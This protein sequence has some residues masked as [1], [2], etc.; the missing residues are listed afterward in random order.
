MAKTYK[1]TNR[2]NATKDR[3]QEL[4]TDP[5]VREQEAV[6]IARAIEAKCVVEH[7]RDGLTRLVVHQK[8]YGRGMD[9]KRDTS[10]VEDV[11]LTIDWNT[12][13]YR[14]DWTW[15]MASQKDRVHVKGTTA[16]VADGNAC[17]V[18]EE[19]HVEV[20]VPMIGKM[21]EGKVAA[22]IEKVRPRWVEWF[23]KKL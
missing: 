20:K 11:T 21:I 19:G 13:A 3:V 9:G 6:E 14:C 12:T 7:P 4:M 18:V 16:L 15:S 5:R 8:E 2:F 10:V 23:E 1:F 22:G 17:K